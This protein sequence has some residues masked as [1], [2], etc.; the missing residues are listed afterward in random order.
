MLSIPKKISPPRGNTR[1]TTLRIDG[2]PDILVAEGN[3]WRNWSNGCRKAL[4]KAGVNFR[5]L[6]TQQQN[7]TAITL[8]DN[9]DH[10]SNQIVDFNQQ[11]EFPDFFYENWTP[12]CLDDDWK[13]FFPDVDW[14]Y[15]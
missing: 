5:N 12:L 7:Q 3:K 14:P 8:E 11:D 6:A 10:D 9:D 2:Y 15:P 13:Y 4:Q 1:V